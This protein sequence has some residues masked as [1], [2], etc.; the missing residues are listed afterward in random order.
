M[1][2]AA[3][4][5]DEQNASTFNCEECGAEFD[6]ENEEAENYS[7]AFML[8]GGGAICEGCRDECEY[9]SCDGCGFYAPLRKLESVLDKFYHR[10]CKPTPSGTD[11]MLIGLFRGDLCPLCGN[12]YPAHN[13]DCESK[14]AHCE[15]CQKHTTHC[16]HGHCQECC[17]DDDDFPTEDCA[18]CQR[19]V[20]GILR[21]TSEGSEVLPEPEEIHDL[22]PNPFED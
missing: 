19:I 4:T 8:K 17:I 20:G 14:P 3:E 5:Q 13:P 2:A 9:V 1:A 16:A 11:A 18:E 12:H 21:V 15:T 22:T 10:D 6:H 7:E